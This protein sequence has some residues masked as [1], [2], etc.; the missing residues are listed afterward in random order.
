MAQG[1]E[2]WRCVRSPSEVA[3]SVSPECVEKGLKGAGEC[4]VSEIELVMTYFCFLFF[5][6]ASKRLLTMTTKRGVC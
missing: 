3:R 1:S 4:V 5:Q 6:K 2:Q